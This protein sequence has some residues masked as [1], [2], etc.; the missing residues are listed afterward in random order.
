MAGRAHEQAYFDACDG[1]FTNYWWRERS[2]AETAQAAARAGGR[3]ADVYV[4]VD[5]FA[6]GDL[7]YSAGPGCGLAVRLVREAGLSLALF[8]PGWSLEVGEAKGRRG[9]EAKRADARFWEALGVERC[10]RG[11]A[12]GSGS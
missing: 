1:I 3:A 6:R 4:G 7:C 11:G 9:E 5:C 12:G 8:A 10:F 2:L